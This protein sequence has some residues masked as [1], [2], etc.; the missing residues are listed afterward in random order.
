MFNYEKSSINDGS[1][2]IHI[3]TSVCVCAS[4]EHD[5]FRIPLS[6]LLAN[7]SPPPTTKPAMP[8]YACTSHFSCGARNSWRNASDLK[9]DTAISITN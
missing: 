4:I 3:F 7:L 8:H 6:N 9:G 2:N 5:S 1:R